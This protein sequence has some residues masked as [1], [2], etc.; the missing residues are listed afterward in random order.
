MKDQMN[1]FKADKSCFKKKKKKKK[2]KENKFIELLSLTLT[3]CN[4]MNL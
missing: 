4:L 2:E 1:L 3:S